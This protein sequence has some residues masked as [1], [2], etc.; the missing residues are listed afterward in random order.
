MQKYNIRA[1]LGNVPQKDHSRIMKEL[2][3]RGIK[4]HNIY[5]WSKIQ[6][7]DNRS[8]PLDQAVDFAEVLEIEIKDI[9]S[10]H[11]KYSTKPNQ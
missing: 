9:Y 8:I 2:E 11:S 5:Q 4:R 7:T 1:I 10:K 3:S 6:I